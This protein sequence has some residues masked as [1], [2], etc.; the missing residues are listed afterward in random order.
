MPAGRRLPDG[1]RQAL[2]AEL[3]GGTLDVRQLDAVRW[4][5][6]AS[7]PVGQV[8]ADVATRVLASAGVKLDGTPLSTSK[9]G[10]RRT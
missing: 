1:L 8:T 2:F 6:Q 10:Q 7:L 4:L 9:Q 5:E 3:K